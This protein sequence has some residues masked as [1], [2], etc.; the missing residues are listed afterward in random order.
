MLMMGAVEALPLKELSKK[1]KQR[2]KK[3]QKDR[4]RKQ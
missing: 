3:K 1:K 4:I 2:K